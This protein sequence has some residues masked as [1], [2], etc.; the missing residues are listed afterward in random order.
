[1]PPENFR[2]QDL[3]VA[4]GQFAF[5]LDST[6]GNVDV[7]VGP[8]K[9]SLSGTDKPVK[10][11]KEKR[12]FDE[13]ATNDSKQ[14]FP[15]A[16]EGYYIV[17]DSPVT[18]VVDKDQ[19]PQKGNRS[20]AIELAIG[21]KVNVPGPT[22]FPLYPGQSV[23]V[24]Q[25]HH[26]RSNQYLLVRVYNEEQ[27]RANWGKAV[28]KGAEGA[29]NGQKLPMPTSISMGQLLVIKG[30]DVS[31]Y[32][33]PTGAEVI[34]E[35]GG[36]YVRNAETL[37]QLE[38]CVLLN[39]NGN[40]RYVEGPGVVFP[41]P[42]ETFINL[43]GVRKG[44]AIELNQ[45]SGLYIKVIKPYEEGAKKFAAGDELFITGKEQAIY[46]PRPEHSIIKY[47]DRVINYAVAIPS[48]EG[49]YVLN[50]STGNV[51]IEKGPS[52]F[53]PDPRKEVIVR[54]VM[55]APQVAILYPGNTEALNF[56]KTLAESELVNADSIEEASISNRSML[57][58]QLKGATVASRTMS[59]PIYD[60]QNA[61]VMYTSSGFVAGGGGAA[62]SAAETM[63]SAPDAIQRKLGHTPPR[64]I[65]L[66]TKYDG[67]VTVEVWSGYASLF[68]RKNGERRVVVGPQTVFL[69]YDENV[70]PIEL[71]KGTP[72]SR[73][74]MLRTAFLRVLNNSVS[75][76]IDIETKD[77]FTATIPVRYHLNFVGTEPTKWF[78][79]E[80]YVQ[81]LAERLRSIVRR[82]AKT[83]TVK[84]IKENAIDLLRDLVLG[85][86]DPATSGHRVGR[87]FEENS[88]QIF[89]LDV[90]TPK[91]QHDIDNVL[92]LAEQKALNQELELT[93]KQRELTHVQQM[94]DLTRQIAS[95]Q[96]AT[97]QHNHAIARDN[98]EI[99]LQTSLQEVANESLVAQATLTD[100]A[101]T[102]EALDAIATAE[103][104][105]DKAIQALEISNLQAKSNIEVN[106][107]ERKAA[108]VTPQL[109]TAI[110]NA[111]DKQMM[112]TI[113]VAVSPVAI[114]QG[115]GILEVV[116][117]IFG[118]S[119]AAEA[120]SKIAKTGQR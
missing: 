120:L 69:E 53:L 2:E 44:S 94:Q 62:A 45:I 97:V 72:K 42:T 40:K 48:G 87:L 55:P 29:D 26:L 77:S 115:S 25:G 105:R 58:S 100:R 101:A 37:E 104:E 96:A 89:D 117:R 11:N 7:L 116:E 52:M 50:R 27:A 99:E 68:V 5:V 23:E 32:I 46:F 3:V 41:E 76:A 86:K 75:D 90:V 12:I 109:I 112:E 95:A 22:S 36:S 73:Q 8:F 43:S 61:Q 4:P 79:V 30:T 110:Q 20:N 64:T 71:S 34:K 102:Q 17:V 74:T 106:E 91:I 118:N 10:W 93:A 35:E 66:N 51:R 6:K 98:L 59:Q 111:S 1:M 82:E 119:V 28:V 19:H 60:P 108:A 107:L 57:R 14:Q 67:V 56:N 15:T 16:S 84:E 18:S 13:V 63:L 114:V 49:R 80:N 81:F 54:R 92:K 85:S 38:F 33:P 21:R 39:E 31:F 47:G 88:M 113:A 103:I 78:N 83:R 9:T 65:T 70:M 24:I